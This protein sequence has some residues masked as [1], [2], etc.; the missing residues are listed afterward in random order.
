M[1]IKIQEHNIFLFL[2]DS[3]VDAGRKRE[4]GNDLGAG[5]VFWLDGELES[6]FPTRFIKMFNRG[7]AGDAVHNILERLEENLLLKP[8]VVTIMVGINDATYRM[9]EPEFG[10]PVPA[11]DFA[12]QYRNLLERIRKCLSD[13]PIILMTPYLYAYTSEH[14][15][16]KQFLEQYCLIIEELAAEY[17]CYLVPLHRK[18]NMEFEKGDAYIYVRDGVHPTP[19]G[20]KCIADCWKKAV[21]LTI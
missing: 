9:W 6:A 11:M 16:N 12:R 10:I 18:L 5:F 8:D 1:G 15:L 2:G 13:V 7:I 20:V 19:A 14:R 4:D 21:G 17:N 3:I